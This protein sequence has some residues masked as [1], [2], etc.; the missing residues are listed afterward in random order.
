M[1]ITGKIVFV[2]LVLCS[3]LFLAGISY[4][5]EDVITSAGWMVSPSTGFSLKLYLLPPVGVKY[6]RSISSS[7]ARS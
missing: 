6:P 3:V 7:C 1:L 2:L 4:F 5:V